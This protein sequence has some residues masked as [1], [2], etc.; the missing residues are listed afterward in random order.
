MIVCD[1]T[2]ILFTNDLSD[3]TI[4]EEEEEENEKVEDDSAIYEYKEWS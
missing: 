2:I 4:D 1:E 3:L